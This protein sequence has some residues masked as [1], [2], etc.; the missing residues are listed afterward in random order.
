M[1]IE[2]AELSKL[3]GINAKPLGTEI[4]IKPYVSWSTSIVDVAVSPAGTLWCT[5]LRPDSSE[6]KG[7]FLMIYK[8]EI[9][10]FEDPII[11][12]FYAGD[13]YFRTEIASDKLDFE[14]NNYVVVY[15]PLNEDEPTVISAYV[16]VLLGKPEENL[17]GFSECEGLN[18]VDSG[19]GIMVYYN[20]PRTPL[21]FDKYKGFVVARKGNELGSGIEIAKHQINGAPG[22][23]YLPMGDL[24]EGEVYNIYTALNSIETPLAGCLFEMP[25]IK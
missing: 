22:I 2:I 1:S 12:K 24:K 5:V 8:E 7:G 20:F 13:G 6:G 23:M 25:K 19:D 4:S 14:K 15:S 3:K 9:S 10:E 18:I 17:N 16:N 21:G 11:K